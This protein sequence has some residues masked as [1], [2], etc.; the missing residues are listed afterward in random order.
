MAILKS[1]K[2]T[3]YN[4][5]CEWIMR[6]SKMGVHFATWVL[7]EFN[8][9][10]NSILRKGQAECLKEEL[11]ECGFTSYKKGFNQNQYTQERKQVE[12]NWVLERSGF[13]V[14]YVSF[15]HNPVKSLAFHT[16]NESH[17]KKF[18][19]RYHSNMAKEEFKQKMHDCECIWQSKQ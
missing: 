17:I 14:G 12:A 13:Y 6:E 3:E 9:G 5:I 16:L 2:K 4:M 11:R 7:G 18:K 19:Q 10:A 15:F 8:V 1:A